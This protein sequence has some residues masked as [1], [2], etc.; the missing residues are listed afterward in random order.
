MCL[1][2][3]SF[4]FEPASPEDPCEPPDDFPE[5]P[6]DFP[7]PPDDSAGVLEE[8]EEDEE[9]SLAA[10]FFEGSADAGGVGDGSG[11]VSA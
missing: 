2:A 5:P 4:G 10:A 6:D 9:P 1:I 11:V 7:E 3:G 8:P